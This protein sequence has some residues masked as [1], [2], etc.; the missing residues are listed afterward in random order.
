MGGFGLTSMLVAVAAFGAGYYIASRRDGSSGGMGE[1]RAD[2]DRHHRHVSDSRPG[3]M[4]GTSPDP[5]ELIGE[6]LSGKSARDSAAVLYD[7]DGN[8][9]R[10]REAAYGASPSYDRR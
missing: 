6:R 10:G 8:P 4:A 3:A 1:W 7:Q 2:R 9:I 5:D